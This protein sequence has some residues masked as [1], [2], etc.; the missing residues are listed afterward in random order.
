MNW[1]TAA[2]L[3]V[4][5]VAAI[6]ATAR[7]VC[8]QEA[9]PVAR[10]YRALFGGDPSNEL[11]RHELSLLVSLNAGLDDGLSA[12][13]AEQAL[14]AGTKLSESYLAGARLSYNLSS[15]RTTAAAAAAT[16]LPYFSTQPDVKEL[17]YSARANAAYVW[18][19]TSMDA[20]AGFSHSPFYSP[21]F[22]PGSSPTLTGN[23]SGFARN[24]NDMK[25]AAASVTRRFGRSAGATA[26]Y[27]VFGLVFT[28]E[29]RSSL[30]Q[31]LRL[32][33]DRQVSRSVRVT[34]SY[35]HTAW[36]FRPRQSLTNNSSDDVNVGL[37]YI[38]ASPRGRTLTVNASVGV[39][40]AKYQDARSKGWR[41]SLSL[42]QSLG[43]RWLASAAY[44]R[45][46]LLDSAILEP[47]WSDDVSATIG[48]SFGRRVNLVVA[49]AYAHRE[50]VVQGSGGFNSYSL[51]TDLQVAVSTTFAVTVDTL[52]YRYEFP[53]GY[54][55]PTGVSPKL[56]R[57]RFQVGARFWL[58][59]VRAGRGYMPQAGSQQRGE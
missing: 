16:S 55:L 10:P 14:A 56:G 41:G 6:L 44:R 30:S 52:Y 42:S 32:S 54:T 45:S 11:F 48:G 3:G 12:S 5:G 49:A 23:D 7:P 26:A 4:V 50:G 35:G 47:V 46:T 36:A 9:K 39:T 51:G 21:A 38:R 22:E 18:G 15:R 40:T 53:T 31:A 59:F 20:S 28:D 17:A 24:P 1:R 29:D 37:R 8:A 33:A 13:S 27:D 43:A 57:H 19:Q 2:R 25:S 34:G 58:P